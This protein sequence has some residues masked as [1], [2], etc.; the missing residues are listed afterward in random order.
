MNDGKQ[1]K[2]S[3]RP[4]GAQKLSHA[5]TLERLERAQEWTEQPAKDVATSIGKLEPGQQPGPPVK[6]SAEGIVSITTRFPASL[7]AQVR[8]VAGSTFGVTINSFVVDAVREKL[9]RETQGKV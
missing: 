1:N 2:I 5:Q 8:F 7:A 4:P 9:A 6:P 3:A